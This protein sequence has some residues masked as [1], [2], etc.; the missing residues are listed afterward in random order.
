MEVKKEVLEAIKKVPLLSPSVSQL[1]S[2]SSDPDFSLPEFVKVVSHDAILTAKIIKIVNSAAYNLP[3]EVSTVDQA[4]TMLG[5]RLIVGIALSSA[6]DGIMTDALTGYENHEEGVWRH[7]LYCAIAARMIG[8]K[9]RVEFKPD[10][11]FTGGLL[12]DIGKAV[13]SK[14]LTGSSAEVLEGIEQGVTGDYLI[15]EKSIIGLDH[16]EVGYEVAK[17]WKLPSMLQNIIRYHHNP[18]DAPEE[19]K[20]ACYAVHLGDV[21]S[22][23]AGH[24]TGS[25]TMQYRLDPGFNQYFDLDESDLCTL[26]FD[27]N[28]EYHEVEALM[29]SVIG[30]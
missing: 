17:S 6:G 3:V 16:T 15:G 26:I 4:A 1:L 2:I 29:A 11:A 28:E 14:F 30:G 13:I 25:D 8:K 18:A 21:L 5:S 27:C 24:G 12:H 22:M 20:V 23:M 7:D 19:F 10:L 9:A